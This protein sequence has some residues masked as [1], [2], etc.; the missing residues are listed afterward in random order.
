[1][2]AYKNLAANWQIQSETVGFLENCEIRRKF[3]LARDQAGMTSILSIVK[4][5]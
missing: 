5:M 1:M 4:L 3:A 2:I